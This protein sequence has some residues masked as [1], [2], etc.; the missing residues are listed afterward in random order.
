MKEIVAYYTQNSE[1]GRLE[2]GCGALEF[3]RTQEL[4]LR[5][6]PPPPATVFDIGGG[7][8]AYA[9]WLSEL[10]HRVHLL[11]LVESQ[12]RE[13]RRVPRLRSVVVGDA[14][15]LPY[16]AAGADAAL[17]LGPLY[18]LTGRPARMA[19]LREAR[20]LLRSGGLLFA[21]AISRYASLLDAL[22]AGWIDEPGALPMVQR[23]L[24]EGQH[25]NA[26]G[27]AQRFTTAYFHRPEELACEIRDAGYHLIAVSAVEGPGWMARQLDLRCR[28]ERLKHQLLDL[29]RRVEEAPELIG[30]SPHYLAT[31]RA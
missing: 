3:A 29:L 12:A 4:V 13:A 21:S 7:V 24:R 18:H 9:R 28:D 16:G 10:G 5:Y 25:R 23:D 14:Q 8:G 1:A 6:L 22:A 30:M 19:A 11:D 17:L 15:A 2:S 26:G 20:R 31:A 27:N